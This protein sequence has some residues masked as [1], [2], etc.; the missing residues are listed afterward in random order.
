[1]GSHFIYVTSQLVN[2]MMLNTSPNIL[3]LV[4]RLPLGIPIGNTSTVN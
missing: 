2:V 3:I 4:L 1:M